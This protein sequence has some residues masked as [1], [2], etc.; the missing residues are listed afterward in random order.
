MFVAMQKDVDTEKAANNAGQAHR[1]K[2]QGPLL[3]RSQEQSCILPYLRS[4]E[5]SF[6]GEQGNHL[7]FL[8]SQLMDWVSIPSKQ[9]N[10]CQSPWSPHVL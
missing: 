3:L 8:F 1:R 2:A 9:T 4:G 10:L 5:L 6:S 7:V